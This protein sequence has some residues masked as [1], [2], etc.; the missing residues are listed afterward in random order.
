MHSHPFTAQYVTNLNLPAA[1]WSGYEIPKG[2][3]HI[4]P[5][6]VHL[7]PVALIRLT[8]KEVSHLL[9]RTLQFMLKSV[10]STIMT[11]G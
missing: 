11:T 7:V 2:E 3:V 10:C 5:R 9:S 8:G 6:V 4:Q 1:I